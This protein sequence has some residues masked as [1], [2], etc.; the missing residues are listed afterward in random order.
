MVNITP[1][2]KEHLFSVSSV[3]LHRG[4]TELLAGRGIE[5]PPTNQTFKQAPKARRG[6]AASKTDDL[7]ED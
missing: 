7:F 3:P 4:G 5:H 6:G 1:T 2:H